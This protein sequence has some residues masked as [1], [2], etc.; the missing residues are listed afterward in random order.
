MWQRPQSTRNVPF[1]FMANYLSLRVSLECQLLSER[2]I[3][4]NKS[5]LVS[6]NMAEQ[7]Q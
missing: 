3:I 4:T 5:E 6:L 7:V 2:T 1:K